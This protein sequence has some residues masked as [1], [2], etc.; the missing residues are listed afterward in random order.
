M[1]RD[2]VI[3][4]AARLGVFV[5]DLPMSYLGSMLGDN[6]RRKKYRELIIEKLRVRLD[7]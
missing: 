2:V 7:S 6:P 4:L 5:G 1:Q 3:R